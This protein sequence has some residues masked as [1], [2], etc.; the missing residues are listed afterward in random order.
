MA[1]ASHPQVPLDV[2][3]VEGERLLISY[4]GDPG[5]RR[6][7]E[8]LIVDAIVLCSGGQDELCRDLSKAMEALGLSVLRSENQEPAELIIR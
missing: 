4:D 3:F 2:Y 5:N 1:L 7:V 6:A 8:D